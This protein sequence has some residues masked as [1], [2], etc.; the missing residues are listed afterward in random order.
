[1]DLN[2][3]GIEPNLLAEFHNRRREQYTEVNPYVICNQLNRRD[4]DTF[5]E[6]N[7]QLDTNNSYFIDSFRTE[8]LMDERRICAQNKWSTWKKY[9]IA[10]C[11]YWKFTISST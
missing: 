6:D 7:R 10:F 4:S 11:K 9:V 3:S 1:M 8:L 5:S 2:S